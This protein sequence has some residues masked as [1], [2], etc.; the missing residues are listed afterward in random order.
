[1]EGTGKD[2]GRYRDVRLA[3]IIEKED[4]FYNK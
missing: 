1:V 4:I 2:K 3:A